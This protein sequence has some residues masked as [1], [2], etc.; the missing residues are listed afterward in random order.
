MGGFGLRDWL[1]K[2]RQPLR[3]AT[4]LRREGKQKGCT[5]DANDA[6]DAND[7]DANDAKD[8]NAKNN[9]NAC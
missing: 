6:N 1:G 2:A 8:A 7:V 4:R 5:N 9:A 3:D